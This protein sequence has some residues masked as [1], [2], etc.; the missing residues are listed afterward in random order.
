MYIYIY[1]YTGVGTC[2]YACG[3]V[4]MEY[5]KIQIGTAGDF[6]CSLLAK[7]ANKSR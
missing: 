3:W 2:V 4:L 7:V 5:T 1:I 6:L